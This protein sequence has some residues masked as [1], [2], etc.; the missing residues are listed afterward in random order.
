MLHKADEN[1]KQYFIAIIPP[2]PVYEE[3]LAQKRYFQEKYHSKAALNSP[4]HITLHM[5]FRYKVQKESEMVHKLQHFVK[6]FDPIK[7]C[8]DNFASFPPRVIFINVA[9]SEALSNFQKNIQRFCRKELNQFNANYRE[10]AFHPH[11]TLAFRDLKKD[12]YQ[13]AW[14][15]FKLKEYKAEFMADKLS[16]LRHD[17]QVWTVFKD[18]NLQSSYST[19][20]RSELATTEG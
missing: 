12:A 2:S 7:V 5:P 15:E 1:Q 3:A 6:A 10:E 16:L 4:P 18:F 14:Q 11:L 20:N 9:P 19:D 13:E 17:G 8:L